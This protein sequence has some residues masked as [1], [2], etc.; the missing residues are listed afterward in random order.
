VDREGSSDRPVLE[1]VATRAER[2]SSDVESLRE[3]ADLRA[4]LQRSRLVD[5][6][7]RLTGADLTRA[8]AAREAM[9]GVLA[10][11]IDGTAPPA[12]DRALVNALAAAPPPH[13]VLTRDGRVARRGGLAAALAALAAD[14]VDLHDSPDR[15]RLHWCADERCTRP[16]IDR[17]RGGR[18]RWCGM[19]GCGDRAK[20]AA[21]RARRRGT[22]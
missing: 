13:L 4:W 14:V 15:A 1:F 3:P 22:V 6:P 17:S 7:G 5:D 2:G 8:R 9:F 16:F 21:Y 20:A 19:K 12:R 18:R 11:I 10:A